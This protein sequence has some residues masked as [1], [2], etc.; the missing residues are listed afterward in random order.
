MKKILLTMFVLIYSSSFAQQTFTSTNNGYW[1]NSST[2]G[3]GGVPG[4]GD[5]A[6]IDGETVIIQNDAGSGADVTIG[7]LNFTS[8]SLT[9]RNDLTLSNG[10]G[11]SATSSG[12][13]LTVESGTLTVSDGNFTNAGTISVGAGMKFVFT[14]GTGDTFTNSGTVDIT[15]DSNSFGAIIFD[16]TYSGSVNNMI[17]SRYVEGNDSGNGAWDLIGPPLNGMGISTFIS[18]NGDL[19]NNPSN[20]DVAL[21]PYNNINGWSTYETSDVDFVNFSV[22]TG[23]QMATDNGSNLEFK[24]TLSTATVN[25]S[26]VSNETDPWGETGN[27]RF[28]LVANPYA[29]Y[30]NANSNAGTNNV[31]STNAAVLEPGIHQA[32]WAWDGAANSG[33]G[34][35]ST[36]TNATGA[37]YL[38][39]GQA[40]MIGAK[41]DTGDTGTFSYTT[42]MQNT[43]GSGDDFYAGDAMDDNRAELF[44]QLDQSN[45]SKFTE[46]YFIEEGSDGIDPTYDGALIDFADPSFLIYSRILDNEQDNGAKIS[47]N[48]LA[49]SEMWNKIIPLGINAQAGQEM[50][51]GI[52]HRTTPADLNIYLED[53]FE[54]TMT[55]IKAG[56]YT[57]IPSSDINGM[58]RFFI[59]ITADTMSNGEVSTNTLNAYKESNSSYIT[60][61]GLA[62][63]S[64]NINVSLYNILGRKVLDTSLNNNINTQTISTL[65]MASGIYVIELESGNDRLTKKLIIQ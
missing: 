32:I 11:N 37:K 29:S 48:A 19:A 59:H 51:I 27:T 22:G 45:N 10:S 43:S 58:G 3:G 39:P 49:Y 26:I 8:G 53:A 13:T 62:T 1:H 23:Y 31:I 35:Y 42:N 36:I 55:D 16:G 44:I 25:I 41:G 64:N 33:N 24:G 52:S 17:Y 38:A 46:F 63:Q 5:T 65:G 2:W 60:I 4:S 57:L 6:I 34:S 50:T 47:V 15:S 18:S 28:N 54:G 20:D 12:T 7:R 61:E 40:F 56:D 21:G 9:L 30:I 14:S